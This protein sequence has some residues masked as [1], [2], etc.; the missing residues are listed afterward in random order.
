[1]LKKALGTVLICTALIIVGWIGSIRPPR[2]IPK[3]SSEDQKEGYNTDKNCPTFASASVT[4]IGHFIH[5]NRDDITAA[6]TAVVAIF[7]TVLGVFTIRLAR[8]TRVAADAAKLSADAVI[9]VEL[10]ILALKR[11]NLIANGHVVPTGIPLPQNFKPNSTITN[12]GHSPA[13]ITHG[14]VEWAVINKLPLKPEYKIIVPYAPGII[15]VKD[16][17]IPLDVP[18]QIILTQDQIGE[19]AT[20]QKWLWIFGFINYKDFLGNPHE[21]RFCIKWASIPQRDGGPVGFVWDDETPPE[22]TRRT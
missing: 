10:P 22:Y 13:E 1:M 16:G 14:C 3:P 6:S 5:D 9:R 2:E 7:T 15:V 11:A 8:S 21:S 17:H 19:V 4:Y 20:T 12:L 18:C